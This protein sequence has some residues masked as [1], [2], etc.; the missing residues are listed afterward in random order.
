MPPP[1]RRFLLA[2][3]SPA[4]LPVMLAIF[5]P[6]SPGTA[7]AQARPPRAERIINRAAERAYARKSIAEARTARAEAR[8]AEIAPLVPVPPPPRPATVRRMRRAGVPLN[9]QPPLV[10]GRVPVIGW[11]VPPPVLGAP[12][13]P[14]PQTMVSATAPPPAR[15]VAT[16]PFARPATPQPSLPVDQESDGTRSVLATAEEPTA[17]AGTNR[18]SPTVDTGPPIELLPTPQPQ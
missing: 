14:A 2:S 7:Q 12:A 8:V 18:S 16:A 15:A 13:S 1:C 4:L 11:S 17:A 6:L 9:G 3:C 10:A 5:T